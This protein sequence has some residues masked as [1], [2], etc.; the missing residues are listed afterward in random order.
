MKV[1]NYISLK[2]YS[3]AKVM[4]LIITKDYSSLVCLIW[5]GN[6]SNIITLNSK[7]LFFAID[8]IEPIFFHF[9]ICL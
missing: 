2:K 7:F 9:L 5:F 3:I 8:W 6:Y 4:I 1:I